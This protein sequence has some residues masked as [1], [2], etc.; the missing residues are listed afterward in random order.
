MYYIFEV[1]L[2]IFFIFYI[3]LIIIFILFSTLYIKLQKGK[4]FFLKFSLAMFFIV[5]INSLFIS[6]VSCYN[7][8]LFDTFFSEC[9]FN[10]K[11]EKIRAFFTKN[12]LLD[13]K[14]KNI[15]QSRRCYP[16][17]IFEFFS[18]L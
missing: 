8:T 12:I 9:P 3:T 10:F 5:S 18:I 1:D 16:I 14:L 7:S 6:I 11:P 13:N 15:C 17:N 2:Y 4:N